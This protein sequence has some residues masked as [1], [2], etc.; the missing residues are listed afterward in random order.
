M[1]LYMNNELEVFGGGREGRYWGRGGIG[2]GE[3]LGNG[4]YW[5]K[6]GIGERGGIGEGDVL[7]EGWVGVGGKSHFCIL[8]THNL[9]VEVVMLLS[10]IASIAIHGSY[11]VFME[12]NI[13]HLIFP[14]SPSDP[15]P[16]PLHFHD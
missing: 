11:M 13:I 6:G 12:L 10:E 4:R 15:L 1:L 2:K 9:F 3:V 5:G 8:L 14:S 7:G 16:P